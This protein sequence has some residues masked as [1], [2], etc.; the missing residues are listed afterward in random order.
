VLQY[1]LRAAVCGFFAFV[2][3]V[4]PAHAQLNTQHLL[5]SVGLKAGS[6]PPPHIYVV[7]PVFYVYRTDDVR[8]REGNRFP[9]DASIT[10]VVYGGG[11][12]VVTTKKVLGGFYGF[13]VL[14]PVGANNRIQGTEIDMNPGGGLTDSVIA[15]INL[16]W[17]FKRAD[18][19]AGYT[20]FVPTG[21]YSDGATDNTGFGM[22]GH[23]FSFGT[24]VYLNETKQYHAATLV[25]FDFQSEKEDSETK[26]G[27]AMNL[28]GGVGAD[29][30]KGGLTAGLNYY[31]SFKLTDDRIEGIPGILIRG[32]DKVF[33]LGPEVQ[34]ALARG[35]K[36]Y[37]FLK[38]NYQW[39]LYARTTTK[40]SELTILA[41]FLV[42]SIKLPN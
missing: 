4:V 9:I 29:F 33:A 3:G 23:E 24:T 19:V 5:G 11:I 12:N 20:I 27:N 1:L 17:H 34:L 7:A 38:V 30:L 42:P 21:R 39:E 36:L 15:P 28:E 40:G 35:G 22:W 37:G 41:S 32:K 18:A 8:D 31:A 25:S 16:G 6:Q 2:P 26:V 10:S 14:F 13:Q